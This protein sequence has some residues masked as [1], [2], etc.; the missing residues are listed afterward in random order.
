MEILLL[1][2]AG[3]EFTAGETAQQQAAAI[4][5]ALNNESDFSDNYE[6]KTV[7][8]K[9]VIT[10]KAGLATGVKP[11]IS[12]VT[13]AAVAGDYDL[14]VTDANKVAVGGKYTI[15]GQDIKVTDDATDAGLA[16]GTAILAGATAED[17]AENL[18]TALELNTTLNVKSILPV[19]ASSGTVNF[20]QKV[21]H[22]SS[23]SPEVS[24]SDTTKTGFE[25]TF[26]IGANSGQSMTIQVEDMRSAA[27]G[28]S[29]DTA[30]G[31]VTAGNGKVA[32]YVD[33]KNVTDGS[34]S[35]KSEFAL[36]VSSH[37]KASAAVSVI[38]DAIKTVSTERSKLGSTKTV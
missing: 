8:S 36:D 14:T 4:A 35:D 21:G 7:D 16:K 23:Q 10:E 19:T 24:T 33:T 37:E 30:S 22:E 26:Q 20:E 34:T 17:Q 9:L 11:A 38:N 25:A 12:G 15:D 6:A 32:S 28:I 31:T 18:K 5:T 27:L 29:G 2:N 3:D 1:I 13:T